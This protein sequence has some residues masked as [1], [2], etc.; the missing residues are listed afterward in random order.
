VHLRRDD[1]E[2]RLLLDDARRDA[3]VAA[4]LLLERAWNRG[5]NV[6]DKKINK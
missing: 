1:V 2:P 4:L 6:V 5:E 3:Q